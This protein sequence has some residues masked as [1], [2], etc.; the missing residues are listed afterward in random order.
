MCKF[1]KDLLQGLAFK[2]DI[3]EKIAP[4]GYFR[5]MDNYEDYLKGS[6]F[7]PSL[8]NEIDKGSE[9]FEKHRQKIKSLNQAMFVMFEKDQIIFPQVS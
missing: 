5:N 1:E 9:N 6:T 8:N 2:P 3:Q 4:A 7:L